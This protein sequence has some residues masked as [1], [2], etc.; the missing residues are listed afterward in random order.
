MPYCPR[1]VMVTVT[2]VSVG[3]AGKMTSEYNE[4]GLASSLISTVPA[5]FTVR[6]V[7]TPGPRFCVAMR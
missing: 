1:F 5:A 3:N 6:T 7:S 4:P 2:V